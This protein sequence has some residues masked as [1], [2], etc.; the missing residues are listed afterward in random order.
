MILGK[1]LTVD[2]FL[3]IGPEILRL[4]LNG[5]VLGER[6]A[7]YLHGSGVDL[8]TILLSGGDGSTDNG[9]QGYAHY[10][11]VLPQPTVTNH[12]VK[13]GRIH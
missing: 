7:D 11:R 6:K 9:V 3:Q 13:V 4:H 1:Y 5:G 8:S 10:V 12:Y 2:R